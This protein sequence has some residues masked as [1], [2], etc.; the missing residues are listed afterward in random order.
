[1]RLQKFIAQSGIASRRKAE[2][3]IQFGKVTVNGERVTEMGVQIDP[4]KDVVKVRGEIITSEKKIYI[5]FHKP[6]GYT[7]TKKGFKGEKNIYELLPSRFKSLNPV[8]RLDK[9]SSGLLLMSNDGEWIEK[10]THP[11]N[12]VEKEYRVELNRSLSTMDEITMLKGIRDG[13]DLL[14]AKKVKKIQKLTYSII[15]TEGKNR[16]IR[17]MIRALGSGVVSLKRVRVEKWRL[18]IKPGEFEIIAK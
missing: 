15:L 2:E 13:D 16:E 1:M 4:E 18:N 9:D 10:I 7:C 5:I 11:R 6:E 12:E 8:G 3:L 14:K 17:R